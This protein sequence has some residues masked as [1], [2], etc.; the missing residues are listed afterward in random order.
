MEEFRN[1]SFK[2]KLTGREEEMRELEKP[3][4]K[5]QSGMGSTVLISGEA[6][7]GKTRLV[8]ELID[9][10]E[11]NGA[12][13][14]KGWC[15]A[16]NLEP[17]LPFKEA[18]RDAGLS[19][20]ISE[21]PPP[22]VISAYLI[23]KDG[24]LVTKVERD[25]TELD[26]D[27]FASMLTAVGNFVTDSLSMMGEKQMGELNTIGYGEHSI[28]IRSLEGLSLAVVIEGGS[29]EFL[30]DDMKK[31]LIDI[32]DRFDSWIGDTK[33]A[34]E[35]RPRIQW[36]IDS[37]KYGGKYLVDDPKIKQENLFDK[38]L[39]GLQRISSDQPTI[40]FL[41]DLQWA[42]P[43]TLKLLHYISR[44]TRK[45]KTLIL[46]AYR[47]EDVLQLDDG[48]PHPLKTT[49]QNMSRE[50]LFD[51][52]VLERLDES[53]AREFVRDSLNGT[54]LEDEL[55]K[56]IYRE[57]DGNPL[58]LLEVIY[59]LAEEG[60][61]IRENGLWK[62]KGDVRGL[63]IPS[64]VYDIVVRRL[65][66]LIDEQKELLEC[67]SVVGEEFESGVVGEVMG[68]NRIKLLKNLNKIEQAHR[69]IY[70]IKKRYRFDHTKIREV[71][72][73]GINQELREEYHLVVAESFEM[74]YE[75]NIDEYIEYIAHH[76]RRA[77]DERAVRYLLGAGD[78]AKDR[79][80]N[81]EAV[82]WYNDALYL[83]EGE[84]LKK[85]YQGLGEVYNI[86]GGYDNSL[87]NYCRALELTKGDK[88][89]A[90][91]YGKIADVFNNRGEYGH[92]IKYA[93]KGILLTRKTDM[94]RCGL[95]NTKGWAFML[96]G[97]YDESIELF[98]EEMALSG[99]LSVTKERAQAL[100][101]LGT[102]YVRKGDYDEAQVLLQKAIELREEVDDVKGLGDSLNSLGVVYKNKGE[103]EKAL[104][105]HQRS[106]DIEEDIGNKTGIARSLNN[107]GIVF[108]HK[109]DLDEALRYYNQS[110][111]IAE[112]LEDKRGIGFSLNN[113]GNIYI[114]KGEKNKAIEYYERVLNISEE[115]GDKNG[116]AISLNN[117]GNIY[118]DLYELDKALEIH[119]R[120]LEIEE[121]IGDKS[122]IVYSLNSI[123][124]IHLY[125]D[126]ADKAIEYY[127]ESRR[128]AE[129]IGDITIA[130]HNLCGSAEAWLKKEDLERSEE[131]ALKALEIAQSIGGKGEEGMSHRLLG[132]VWGERRRWVEAAQEFDR[133][134]KLLEKMGERRE[135]SR[136]IYEYGLMLIRKGEVAEGEELLKEA[137]LMFKEMDLDLWM[138]KARD[139]LDNLISA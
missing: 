11:E 9:R 105:Y 67:A 128:M 131:N 117:I 14:I 6:G 114:D 97:D 59:M 4:S 29:S 40:I 81:I 38:V 118:I 119:N 19:Q 41:D 109:G 52:M 28:L 60:Q 71:L 125:R 72:Y 126:D 43:T 76:Y 44:N 7:I 89:R 130:V 116:V 135:L 36:F 16:D 27:I 121:D 90:S 30:I 20:L 111:R 84:D 78:K 73:N 24:L 88:E 49:M 69:L 136:T 110:L 46:G 74:L 120:S 17:L 45:D 66:R 123:G 48:S 13:I 134:L 87:E 129:E 31:T 34:E 115:I 122:G 61:L 112:K 32:G 127:E 63:H 98:K 92:S 22:K 99:K 33:T 25:E 94:E 101:D 23:N 10:A 79:Y 53:A 80:A 26:P 50:D 42:E 2:P 55:L 82:K 132:M 96:Q 8:N 12:N 47:P 106:R 83:S 65:D 102:V 139:V 70:S 75:D 5:V 104:R 1:I 21:D 39:L 108:W 35:V 51:R 103:M 37:R 100:H 95:L 93:D 85:V 3:W 133:G 137:M 68:L 91:L 54:E 107:I 18:F 56:R 62:V 138:R 15:L 124:S 86:M 64:K 57:S 113:I 77:E 58:F